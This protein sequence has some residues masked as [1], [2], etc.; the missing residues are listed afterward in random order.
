[1]ITYKNLMFQVRTQAENTDVGAGDRVLSILPLNHLLELTCGFLGVLFPGGTICFA[2]T[3]FPHE[4]AECMQDRKI[5]A[6]L[7]VPLL[8]RS[9]QSGIERRIQNAPVR[10][11]ILFRLAWLL[12]GI[13]PWNGVRRRLFRRIHQTFGGRL[14]I[15]VSGGAPLSR[16]VSRFLERIGMPILQ[17]YGLT[18]TSPVVSLNMPCANR[19]GSVGRPL[20]GVE[21]RIQDGEILTRG[22]HVMKGYYRNE[23]LTREV[24]DAEGWF[25]TGDL[26]RI[27]ADGFLYVTGRRKSLIVLGGGKKVQPEEIEAVLVES[28]KIQ[29]ICVLGRTACRGP[30]QGQEEVCAVI[31]PAEG[32]SLPEIEAEIRRLG[33]EF[34]PFKRPSRIHVYPEE[35]PKTTT[36]KVKRNVLGEWLA[37]IEAG[38]RNHA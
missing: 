38:E 9:I 26:G 19:P 10:T 24:I 29:E 7:G 17:G 35:L 37:E 18:E 14:R 3:L 21:V 12:A 15:L 13:L 25:H 11:R 36:R 5:R 27:D 32:V 6:M 23:P 20:P 8:Y 2:N 34:A 31:V 16:P 30:N 1:M 4:L 33:A 22:P 28:P